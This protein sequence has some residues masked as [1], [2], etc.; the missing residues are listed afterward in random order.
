[1]LAALF[2][3]TAGMASTALAYGSMS[4]LN[5]CNYNVY[6]NNT[7]ADGYGLNWEHGTMSPN[8]NYQQTYYPLSGEGGWSIKMSLVDGEWDSNIFQLEYNIGINDGKLWYDLSNVNGHP[9]GTNW[10]FEGEG[11]CQPKQTAYQYD[12][13]DANGMQAGCD[14]A[15]SVTVTLC[16]GGPEGG[17]SP[18]SSQIP[19]YSSSSSTWEASSVYPQPEASSVYSEPAIAT[20]QPALTTD[21]STTYQAVTSIISTEQPA[22]TQAFPSQ[23]SGRGGGHGWQYQNRVVAAAVATPSTLIT[24]STVSSAV[25]TDAT[26]PPAAVVVDASG[27]VSESEIVPD[28]TTDAATAQTSTTFVKKGKKH[29]HQRPENF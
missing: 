18:S 21:P 13:D 4:V 7:P 5:H 26:L 15:N 14:S 12:V 6:Y 3:S 25:V 10:L 1:M 27:S 17:E 28:A 23:Q 11:D 2:L 19:S 8:G 16:E 20:T 24:S 29:P 9:F 22:E